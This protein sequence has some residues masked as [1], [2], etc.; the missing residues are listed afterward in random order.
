MPAYYSQGCVELAKY[1]E[2]EDIEQKDFAKT[3]KID[4]AHLNHL[5]KGRK[6]PSLDSAVNIEAATEGK[7]LPK[8]WCKA[9][10]RPKKV[11]KSA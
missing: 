7:V 6:R 5:L 11:R 9:V 4:P 3:A 1:L 2:D 10:K 8:N